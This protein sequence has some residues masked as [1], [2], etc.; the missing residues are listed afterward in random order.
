[1]NVKIDKSRST[2]VRGVSGE[3]HLH[4]MVEFDLFIPGHIAKE[5]ITGRFRTRAWVKDELEPKLLLGNGFLHPHQAIMRIAESYLAFES[6]MK[7]GSP[8]EVDTSICYKGPRVVRKVKAGSMTIIP[9]RTTM[10]VPICSTDLPRERNFIFEPK[11]KGAHAAIMDHGHFVAVTNTK[12]TPQTVTRNER[13]GTLQ[14]FEEDGY[15]VMDNGVRDLDPW[16]PSA[17]RENVSWEQVATS[18]WSPIHP[19]DHTQVA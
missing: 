16:A 13:L 11:L 1:M 9:P 10:K 5:P 6:I 15:F 4:E 2:I 3:A 14:E 8:L 17:T 18:K 12:L 7:N 19:G